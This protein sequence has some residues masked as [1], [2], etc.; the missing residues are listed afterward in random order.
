MVSAWI[1]K[2]LQVEI[3]FQEGLYGTVS[4][5]FYTSSTVFIKFQ[6]GSSAIPMS[7]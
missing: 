2:G 1:E 4:I 3:G 5:K 6:Q 7:Q